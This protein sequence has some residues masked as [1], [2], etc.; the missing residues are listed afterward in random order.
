MNELMIIT[1]LDQ[2]KTALTLAT[3]DFERMRVRDQAAAVKA[4]A[5]VLRRKDLAVQASLLVN[6]A[7]R[8]MARYN[9]PQP[10]GTPPKGRAPT[11]RC[12]GKKGQD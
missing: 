8:E 7:E 6:D 12:A 9:P 4:A 1:R 3:D 11:P 10:R 2:A 5:E